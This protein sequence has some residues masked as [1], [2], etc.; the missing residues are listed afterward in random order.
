MYSTEPTVVSLVILL[1]ICQVKCEDRHGGHDHDREGVGSYSGKAGERFEDGPDDGISP[2]GGESV[3]HA[4]QVKRQFSLS[5]WGLPDTIAYV[6]KYFK[7]DLFK[8]SGSE[9]ISG[10]KV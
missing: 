2:P 7:Y 5:T 8:G 9:E 10:F 4:L 1:L 6:G 3:H